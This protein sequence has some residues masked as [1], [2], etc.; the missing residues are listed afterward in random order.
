MKVLLSLFF[1]AF[2]SLVNANDI[3]ASSSVEHCSLDS[4]SMN[5]S[6]EAHLSGCCDTVCAQHLSIDKKVVI[7]EKYIPQS[8][9][10]VF[11]FNTFY[12]SFS[13]KMILPPPIV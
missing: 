10:V 8:L 9:S 2:M 12:T 4:K 13:S 3:I 6:V 7:S 11:I 1:L 5:M